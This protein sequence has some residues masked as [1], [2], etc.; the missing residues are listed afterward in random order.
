MTA[1]VFTSWLKD[2]DKKLGKQSR[3]IL[4]IVNNA[5]PHP[6]LIDLKNNTLEFLPPNTSSIIQPLNMGTIKNLKTHYRRLLVTYILKAIEDNLV[7]PSTCAIDISFK[8]NISQVIQFAAKSSRKVSS[9][10]I[11]HCFALCGFI[12]LIDLPIPPIFFIENDVG[13]CVENL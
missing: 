1:E 5:E 3:K 13:Q 2:W 4:L 6:N 11:Q 10:M 7:T 9:V 8:I 12:P